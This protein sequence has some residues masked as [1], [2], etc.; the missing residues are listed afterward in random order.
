MADAGLGAVV[1]HIRKLVAFRA[2]QETT[3]RQLL[4]QFLA[5][6]DEMAFA[7]LVKRHGP[8]VLAV[9]RRVLRHQQDAEDAFQAT[10]LVL[11]QRAASIRRTEA[12][13]SWLHGVAY[14]IAMRAK[15]DAARRRA[16]ERK[17]MAVSTPPNNFSPEPSWPEIQAVLDEEIQRLPEKYRAVFLLCCLEG[18][19]RT[20]AAKELGLKDATVRS[21]LSQAR[22]QLQRRLSRRGITL[23]ALLG[24]AAV[25]DGATAAVPEA[26]AASTI[27]SVTLF[28]IRKAPIASVASAEVAAL[29]KGATKAM[30]I[31]KLKTV[32]VLLLVAGLVTA[33]A[34]VLAQREPA[35]QTAVLS[36]TDPAKPKA[37]EAELPKLVGQ[38]QG[39]TDRHG[40]PLPPGAI[41]RLGTMRLRHGD[42]VHQVSLSPDGRALAAACMNYNFYLWDVATGRVKRREHR[43]AGRAIAFSANGKT[44]ASGGQGEVLVWDSATGTELRRFEVKA[45]K[46]TYL[47]FAADDKTL[48]CLGE[49]NSVHLLELASGKERHQWEGPRNFLPSSVAFSPDARILAIA[50][51]KDSVIRLYDTAT[52]AELRHFPGHEPYILDITFSPDGRMLI[53]SFGDTLYFY[54]TATGK[55]IRQVKP[56]GWVKTLLFLPD[57]KTLVLGGFDIRLWEV[58]TAKTVGRFTWDRSIGSVECVALSSN[59]KTLAA[60][61]DG[62]THTVA[63]WDV[64]TGKRLHDFGGHVGGVHAV[65]FSPD[66]R[67]LATGASE[68]NFTPDNKVQLWD[69]TTGEAVRQLGQ[70]LGLIYSIA[71]SPNG[72]FLAASN[73][74]GTIRSLDR[75]TGKELRRL[76]GHRGLIT[77]IAFSA[78]GKILASRGYDQ[79][80]RIWDVPAGKERNSFPGNQDQ[81][82]SIALSAD[83]K[84]VAEGAYGDRTVR[85][86][87]AATGKELR[88]VLGF[89]SGS[90]SGAFSPDGKLL[91][92]GGQHGA[93]DELRLLE[94]ATGKEVQ[95]FPGDQQGTR[96]VVFSPDG[97]SLAAVS[98]DS[99]IHLWEVATGKLR[100]KFYGFGE[101]FRSAAFSPDGRFLAFG[102]EDA[103]AYVFD[104][105]WLGRGERPPREFLSQ[106]DLQALWAHL[107][108][109]DAAK[110]FSALSALAGAPQETVRFLKESLQPVPPLDIAQRNMISQWI[111]DLGSDQFAVRQTAS[112]QLEKLGEH[113]CSAI[114]TALEGKPSLEARRRL[115]QLLQGVEGWTPERLRSVRAL[116]VLELIGTPEAQH[117]LTLLAQ[118]ASES[119]LTQEAKA[120]IERLAKRAGNT[121]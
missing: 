11:A 8:L 45:K 44:F 111:E 77:S 50:H 101:V 117:V 91:A 100:G 73:E 69:P 25:T 9:C 30:F 38:K 62:N 42:T 53:S 36:K 26:L 83:G 46:V 56:G 10:F 21:R 13:T 93:G 98:A 87:E 68:R 65:A 55:E 51:K 67:L 106:K 116:E 22:K 5:S 60:S 88:R 95:R 80:I 12:L 109:D 16:H 29:V 102:S 64:P 41:A 79:T 103:T 121:P 110:A 34:G 120:S 70:G 115:E 49:D 105:M 17:V 75:D 76:E 84:V 54:E 58:D 4:G 99:V 118:G 74:D 90:V 71:F 114:R 37:K 94:T 35:P 31:T 20:E 6:A 2:I 59:G 18:K 3:D 63:L 52:G 15:R 28:V 89:Q 39:H 40:D 24:A 48:A 14:R 108:Q 112:R 33:G 27:R 92:A 47:T 72:R 61:L 97:R 81:H 78:D 107:A 1:Q 43:G 7:A 85:L 82:V 32:T 104:V 86:W 113:A 57:G 23:S 19:N 119:R 96:L 66:C